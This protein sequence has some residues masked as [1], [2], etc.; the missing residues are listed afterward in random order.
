VPDYLASIAADSERLQAALCHHPDGAIDW[1]GTWTVQDCAQHVGGAHHVV[2]LVV[3]GRPETSFRALATMDI[4]AAGDPRLAGWLAEGTQSLVGALTAA[5]PD[6]PCWSWWKPERRVGFWPR[7]MAHETAI[8][9]WDAERG[10]GLD[11]APFG[12]DMAVDG[13]DEYLQVFA[14][15]GRRLNGSP[16]GPERITVSA[17]D[18]GHRWTVAFP[19]PGVHTLVRDDGSGDAAFEGPIAGLLLFLWGRL[20]RDRAGV[21]VSGDRALAARW[22]ELV[23]AV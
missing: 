9:R 10:A 19:E 14:G 17:T 16:A 23:P 20:D 4:P 1:C 5:D 15:F 7:R 8:H 18:T 21:G 3:E 12:T 11:P 13:V 2:T 22:R 6:E